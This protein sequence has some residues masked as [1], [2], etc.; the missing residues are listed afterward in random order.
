MPWPTLKFRVE[1]T[2]IVGNFVRIQGAPF[3]ELILDSRQNLRGRSPVDP[4]PWGLLLGLGNLSY[5][6]P[7]EVPTDASMSRSLDFPGQDRLF[8][9]SYG[10]IIS[11]VLFFLISSIGRSDGK[12]LNRWRIPTRWVSSKRYSVLRTKRSFR[13]VLVETQFDPGLWSLG[14]RP[15]GYFY[16][17][18]YHTGEM[19]YFFGYQAGSGI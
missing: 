19:C 7:T 17:R 10:A 14:R 8:P 16:N 1:S 18:L 9:G 3:L 15:L 6:I 12:G 2:G 11:S 5:L 4:K 13:W